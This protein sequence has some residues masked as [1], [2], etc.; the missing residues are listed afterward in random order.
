MSQSTNQGTVSPTHFHIVTGEK[1]LQP[2]RMQNLT[3]R[4]THMYY[5]WPV[6]MI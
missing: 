6:R 3:F 2:D 1:E 4:L 5:N